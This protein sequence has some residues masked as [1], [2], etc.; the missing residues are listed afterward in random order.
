MSVQNQ[1][2]MHKVGRL[3]LESVV[4]NPSHALG[5]VGPGGIG[6]TTLAKWL[7]SEI[8]QQPITK[9]E[10][11]PYFKLIEPEG[12]NLTIDQ[13]RGLTDFLKLKTTG[14]TTLRRFVIIEHADAMTLE[15]QNALLK[16]LEE[17][18]TDTVIILTFSN[19]R[20]LLPTILSRI[21]T[22]TIRAPGR[23][24]LEK[25]AD[26]EPKNFEQVYVLGGNLPGLL[27]ALL[28]DEK[29]H[30]LVEAVNQARELLQLSTFDR[31][32][33]LDSL[34]KD[35]TKAIE[36]TQALLRMAEVSIARAAAAHDNKTVRRWQKVLTAAHDAQ[37]AL[38]V[39]AQTKL[40]VL[41]LLLHI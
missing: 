3:E 14:T 37:N 4:Q 36:L 32:A 27:Y 20:Q 21:Q 25:L 17:P 18:P 19:P 41:N 31:L 23:A 13:I 10:Q 7:V 1:P 5:L 12:N 34:A 28:N 11:Y 26:A 38:L 30:P 6:K 29:S 33:R 8:T 15:A 22:I 9:L 40:V 24:Q 39:N 35:R 2:I 16:S